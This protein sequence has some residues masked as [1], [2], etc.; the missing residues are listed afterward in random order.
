MFYT[1]IGC[2]EHGLSEQQTFALV[3]IGAW[4]A[5]AGMVLRSG[6]A[7]GSDYAFE[8]GAAGVDATKTSIYLP[9][10]G[11][12]KDTNIKDVNYLTLSDKAFQW[13]RKQLKKSGV[14]PYFD[15]MN[16]M[17]QA[18]HAR[19][20]FQVFGQEKIP[21][22]FVVYFAPVDPEGEVMGGTR[23]AVN[24]ASKLGIKTYN[25]RDPDEAR[26]FLQYLNH[27]H[28]GNIS[29]KVDGLYLSLFERR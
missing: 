29:D 25:L 5:R 3:C 22:D 10:S 13:A 24:L 1:G 21:S 6:H 7:S 12:R 8:L 16:D 20:V 19:N 9:W 2:R 23:T 15:S 4:L 11:F 27:L 26:V 14:M 28:N 17:N 18:F